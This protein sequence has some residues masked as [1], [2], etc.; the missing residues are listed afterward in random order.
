MEDL[1][2]DVI[3]YV[4]LLVE[5]RLA[6]DP[7][8]LTAFR[9]LA[10][11][12]HNN[13]NCPHTERIE[14]IREMF[15]DYNQ[16]LSQVYFPIV[17]EQYEEVLRL[18]PPLVQ[19]ARLF[20]VAKMG[21]CVQFMD[22]YRQRFPMYSSDYSKLFNAVQLFILGEIPDTELRD[23]L[24]Q[25]LLE[26]PDFRNELEARVNKLTSLFGGGDGNNPG[27]GSPPPQV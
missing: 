17:Q 25:V 2:R 1:R 13:R 24:R 7:N 6:K 15:G 23:H 20:K 11:H 21:Y 14:M 12:F 18:E 5:E 3:L 8:R 10:Q 19:I 9:N 16:D 22:L 4:N 27:A 26:F